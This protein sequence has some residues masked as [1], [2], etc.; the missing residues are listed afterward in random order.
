MINATNFVKLGLMATTCAL[1]AIPTAYSHRTVPTTIDDCDGPPCNADV[2]LWPAGGVQMQ[3]HLNQ[4]NEPVTDSGTAKAPSACEACD[5]CT[6]TVHWSYT[7]VEKWV[8]T[9]PGSSQE[10]HGNTSG[11]WLM[12]TEC[13][14]D[15]GGYTVSVGDPPHTQSTATLYCL[16]YH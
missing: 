15:T 12:T 1:V 4:D 16:C 9:Q 10:G 2:V 14:E 8:V 13:D 3:V 11:T 5:P 7:G 6:T